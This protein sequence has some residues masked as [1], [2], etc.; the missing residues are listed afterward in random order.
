ME[1]RPICIAFARRPKSC[2]P[3]KSGLPRAPSTGGAGLS[4]DDGD[5]FRPFAGESTKQAEK[6]TACG[7]PDA[8]GAF[9]VT[10]LVRLFSLRMRLRTHLASGVP[11]A[12]ARGT[13]A[14]SFGR[15]RAVITTGPMA[16]GCLK[17]EFDHCGTATHRMSWPDLFRPSRF[18]GMV[19]TLSGSLG[20]SR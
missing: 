14:E 8:S 1:I 9:V 4:G 15:A 7:T 13:T 3:A 16:R 17:I 18:A 10:T 2:G 11:C 19:L 6:P 20:H 5:R 12:L